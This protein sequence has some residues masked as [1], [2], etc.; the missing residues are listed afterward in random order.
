MSKKPKDT[1]TRNSKQQSAGQRDGTIRSAMKY[2]LGIPLIAVI[3]LALTYKYHES[4]DLRNN[5]YRPLYAELSQIETAIQQNHMVVG[6]PT[7]TKAVL[8]EKGEINRL[9]RELRNQVQRVYSDAASLIGTMSAVEEIERT[10]SV[11]IQRIRTKQQDEEWSQTTVAKM[12]SELMSKPG[13]SAIRS[14]EFKHPGVSPGIEA[15]GESPKYV[16]PGALVWGFQDWVDYP[17]SVQTVEQLWSDQQFLI[18][19]ETRENWYFRITRDDLTRNHLTLS[20][21]LRPI[22]DAISSNTDFKKIQAR[23]MEVKAE[24][25]GLRNIIADRIDAPKRL[26]DLLQ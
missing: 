23:R 10:T 14:F 4:E 20:E 19:D 17:E 26:S 24:I 13:Q 1:A 18:F 25:D 8:D 3:G 11:Y 6:F 16:T 2:V 9:P 15:H 22:H 7:N 12:N 5:L 21:F